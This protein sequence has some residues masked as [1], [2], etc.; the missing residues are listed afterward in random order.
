[1]PKCL[2]LC[3]QGGADGAGGARG[4]QHERVRPHDPASANHVRGRRGPDARSRSRRQ[5][6]DA[7]T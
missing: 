4:G 7:V 1:M 5:L 6:R 2:R 3:S